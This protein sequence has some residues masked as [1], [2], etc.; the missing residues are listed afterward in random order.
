M[1]LAICSLFF[2]GPINTSD[3]LNLNFYQ[4][5][6]VN[7]DA[8]EHDILRSYHRFRARQAKA[9][10]LP[11]HRS[12]Q[13]EQTALAF[14]VLGTPDSRALYDFAGTNFLNCTGFQVMG[15]QS[16]VTIQALK[17]MIGTLP[18]NMESYG[19]ML[20]Y[21]IQFDIV[22]FLT[23]AEKVVTVLRLLKCECPKGKPRCDAC[24]KQR[25][26]QDIVREK[27]VLPPGAVQYHRIIRKGLG[28]AQGGR[29][30]TD[31]IF[32]AY[33]K[34]D[35]HFQRKGTDIHRNL[36]VPIKDVIL[37]KTIMIENF[38]GERIEIVTKGGIQDGEERR[39]P[40]KGLPFAMEPAKRGDFVVTL[41]LEYPKEISE[42]QK[43]VLKEKLPDD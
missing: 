1:L 2:A 11:R 24:L 21:P 34:P 42:E 25:F 18:N 23:G 41:F 39:I 10:A 28:D 20:V 8:S 22:D 7:P 30:A 32:V 31:V 3:L 6:N 27:I 5:I 43:K 26:Y 16:D 17:R 35:P 40:K 9:A 36:T 4:L 13:L 15:Y 12:R 19:G 14:D 38:D 37:G 33:M 29:G